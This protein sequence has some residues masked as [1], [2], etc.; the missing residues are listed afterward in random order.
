MP[1]NKEITRLLIAWQ[2]GDVQALE[3][4]GPYIEA[5]LRRLARR[6]MRRERPGHTLQPTAL[7]HEAYLR[8]VGA[9][10]SWQSRAH[11]LAFAARLMRRILVD[12]ARRRDS[13][14]RGG[15]LRA[16]T[17]DESLLPGAEKAPAIV[18][19]DEALDRLA[20]F[21]ARMSRGIELLFFGGLTPEE[22]AEA[23]GISRSTLFE[24]LRLAKAWLKNELE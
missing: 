22:A 17:L 4:L 14:R 16:A 5:E 11:F 21:D 6:Q 12:H 24:D 23:L 10:V 20:R 2:A 9:D 18:E 1:D 19:L 3:S 13:A 8:L 15:P 7:V